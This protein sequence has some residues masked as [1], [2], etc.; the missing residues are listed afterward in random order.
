LHQDDYIFGL[1]NTIKATDKLSFNSRAEYWEVDAKS[2][3]SRG[4]DSGISLTETVE[5]DLWANVVS[6]LEVRYDKVVTSDYYGYQYAE[7]SYI[8]YVM[9]TGTMVRDSS[10]VGIY[11]NVV[12]KF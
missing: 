4:S 1:Y 7:G 12:Y 6:R 9:P 2:G 8:G 10:S 5:Y 3:A 11:A